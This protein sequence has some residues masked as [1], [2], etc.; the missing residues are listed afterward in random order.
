MRANRAGLM[1]ARGL[2]TWTK[3]L[4]EALLWLFENILTSICEDFV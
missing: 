2:S 3:K 4:E 1:E